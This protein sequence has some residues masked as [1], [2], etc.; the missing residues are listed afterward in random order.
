MKGMFTMGYSNISSDEF[1]AFETNLTVTQFGE[2]VRAR[3]AARLS[4]TSTNG[5]MQ[6]EQVTDA[7]FYQEFFTQLEKGIFIDQEGL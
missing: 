6:Y 3:M 5:N 1:S 2:K 4:R 7:K